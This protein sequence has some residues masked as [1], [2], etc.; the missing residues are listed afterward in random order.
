MSLT[1]PPTGVRLSKP[2]SH[3][4]YW[5]F[6]KSQLVVVLAAAGS[7]H[8]IPE[9][10]WG[11]RELAFFVGILFTLITRIRGLFSVFRRSRSLLSSSSHQLSACQHLPL[12]PKSGE[13]WAG[14]LELGFA[15]HHTLLC[16]LRQVV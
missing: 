11:G 2:Q 15:A 10:P 7:V 1:L 3:Q 4:H 13:H 14:S 6:N 5:S 8:V 9:A 12:N 16:E